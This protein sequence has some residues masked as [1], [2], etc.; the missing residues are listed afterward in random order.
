MSMLV[1]SS[2]TITTATTQTT[3]EYIKPRTTIKVNSKFRHHHN[4]YHNNNKANN[5][6]IT[7]AKLYTGKV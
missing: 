7:L 4:I 5:N 2:I 1:V 3:S 6:R